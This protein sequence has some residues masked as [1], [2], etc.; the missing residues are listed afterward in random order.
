M[1]HEHSFRLPSGT[2]NVVVSHEDPKPLSAAEWEAL[3]RVERR[4]H[5]GNAGHGWTD[6]MCN[7]GDENLNWL[8]SHTKMYVEEDY[9]VYDM[10]E[11]NQRPDIITAWIMHE[12]ARRVGQCLAIMAFSADVLING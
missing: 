1:K 11:R 2:V 10:K 7:D 3:E 5:R 12:T 4:I 8:W 6:V 9:R